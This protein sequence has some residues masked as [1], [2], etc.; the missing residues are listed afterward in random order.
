MPDETIVS[1]RTEH[2]IDSECS[3][4]DGTR[5]TLPPLPRMKLFSFPRIFRINLRRERQ[6]AEEETREHSENRTPRSFNPAH[7]L[8]NNPSFREHRLCSSRTLIKFDGNF[9]PSCNKPI[10]QPRNPPS[11]LSRLAPARAIDSLRSKAPKHKS[12]VEIMVPLLRS[13]AHSLRIH[14]SFPTC[15]Q[16]N[17]RSGHSN[18]TLQDSLRQQTSKPRSSIVPLGRGRNSLGAS[19]QDT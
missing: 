15:L 3:N 17:R 4:Q 19:S 9:G 16:E 13:M 5:T 6:P 8:A 10:N 18:R 14:G 1:P 11:S 7:D 12:R 2:H